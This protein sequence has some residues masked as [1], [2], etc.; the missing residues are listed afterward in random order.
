MKA[1][2]AGLM[3]AFLALVGYQIYEWINKRWFK[4]KDFLKTASNLKFSEEASSFLW[5][6]TK[7]KIRQLVTID[8]KGEERL[9][10]GFEMLG[11]SEEKLKEIQAG[12]PPEYITFV[13]DFYNKA[14]NIGIIKSNDKYAILKT[15]QTHSDKFHV[16]NAKLIND[17]RGL[18][19]KAPFKI[20]GAG[21][22]WL[23]LYFEKIPEDIAYVLGKTGELFPVQANSPEPSVIAEELKTAGKLFLWWPASPEDNGKSEGNVK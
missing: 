22:D 21:E 18:D 12:L 2:I 3:S 8:K 5:N 1:L 4:R 20:T 11:I 15:M 14:Q 13:T 16:S 23:E 7:A 17:L 10:A 19:K 9:S 6:K